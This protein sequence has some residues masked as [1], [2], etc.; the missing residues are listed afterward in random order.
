MSCSW[1]EYNKHRLILA[2]IRNIVRFYSTI[3][4]NCYVFMVMLLLGYYA[5][6]Q[7]SNLFYSDSPS[8]PQH[9]LCVKDITPSRTGVNVCVRSLKTCTKSS[10]LTNIAVPSMSGSAYCP[11][12]VWNAYVP[13][14]CSP[15]CGPAF[16]D[17]TGVPIMTCGFLSTLWLP[18]A[19][20]GHPFVS[21]ITAHSP[22]R[23]GA[24][25]YAAKRWTLDKIKQ[26]GNWRPDDVFPDVPKSS[27]AQHQI[28]N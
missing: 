19:V 9:T 22:R 1:E 7:Q 8:D 10:S 24:Q 20:A 13:R 15:L 11:V 12:A 3:G 21:G 2:N 5:L 23:D 4:S 25:A 28:P 26:L 16:I 27:L 6:L 17:V 14:T 18:L